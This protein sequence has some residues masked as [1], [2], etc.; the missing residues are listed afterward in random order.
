[1]GHNP[2]KFVYVI[3]VND[4]TEDEEEHHLIPESFL[5]RAEARK[6]LA[7]ESRW[8]LSHHKGL[9]LDYGDL[10]DTDDEIVLA[11]KDEPNYFVKL[12]ILELEL[13]NTFAEAEGINQNS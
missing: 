6:C 3:Q 1:M 11:E 7:T 12:E 2:K 13:Y 9:T 4:Y 10:D 5:S 8:W